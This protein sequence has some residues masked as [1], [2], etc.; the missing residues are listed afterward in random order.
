M[1][2]ASRIFGD[3]TDTRESAMPFRKTKESPRKPPVLPKELDQDQK[4]Q[5][6]GWAD[7]D[8][9]SGEGSESAMAH[10]ILEEKLREK[11]RKNR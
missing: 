9:L 10:L 2:V 6:G 11:A 5:P 3:G 1:C 7:T 4:P 8:G